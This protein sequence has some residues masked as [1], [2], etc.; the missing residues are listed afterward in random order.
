MTSDT[1]I[2][3]LDTLHSI[4]IITAGQR[5]RALA[6]P[7]ASDVAAMD[8]MSDQLVWMIQRDIVT[9][10]DMAHACTRI[11][12]SHGAE[13]AARHMEIISETLAKYLGARERVNRDTL[14]TLASAALIT[15]AELDRIL[16]HVPQNLL[17]ESPGAALVWMARTGHISGGRLKTF[18]RDG[19]AGDMRRAAILQEVERL[20]REHNDAVTAYWRALLPGP[21]WMWIAVPLLAFSVYIWHTVTP[22]AAPGCTDKDISRTLDGL[23]LRASIDQR[24]SAMRPGAEATLPAVSGIKEVGYASEPRIRGCKATLTID[25]TETAYAFTIEPSAPGKQD[26]AVVGASPAIVEARFGH[27]TA[28]GKFIN[29]AEPVG[30]AEAER[31][32]RAGVDNM[33][34]AAF[35]AGRRAMPE[36]PLS[37]LPKLSTSSPERSREIAEVEP[38]APCREIAAGTTYSCRLLV[39]RND[40]LLAALGRDGSTTLEGDFVFERDGATGPWHMAEGFDEAFVNAVAA[41]RIQGLT[42]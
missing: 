23:M 39:E 16:P 24:V 36:L 34:A 22:S 17:L 9:P 29:K 27:L 15:Q 31:A 4:G 42:R 2:T 13:E 32:F 37:H 10:D 7:G 19:A 35:P 40:P 8:S 21:V 14:G 33:M 26:F 12:T 5:R 1:T 11:E 38:L 18:R 25:K 28:D 20:D 6:D 30:R 41:S 3:G